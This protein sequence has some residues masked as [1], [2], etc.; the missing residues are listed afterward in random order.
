LKAMLMHLECHPFAKGTVSD[1]KQEEEEAIDAT[2]M[3]NETVAVASADQSEWA[4][5]TDPTAD[6]TLRICS[7]NGQSCIVEALSD[8][9]LVQLKQAVL[10][11]TGIEAVR[12]RLI[13]LPGAGED[14]PQELLPGVKL[15]KFFVNKEEE[16]AITLITFAPEQGKWVAAVANGRMKLVDVPDEYR[17]DIQVVVAAM[18]KDGM[19]LECVDRDL[20]ENQEEVIYAAVRQNG[21]ALSYAPN[22]CQSDRKV[23]LAAC[24][25]NSFAINYASDKLKKDID[26]ITQAIAKNTFVEDQVEPAIKAEVRRRRR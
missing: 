1:L 2:S 23:V 26:F 25:S 4:D 13:P 10:E 21:F 8:W 7:L 15:G 19:Q 18:Q 12:Q 5:V 24:S 16:H 9:T 3:D 14:V 17:R 6:L 22:K 20:Q 11:A